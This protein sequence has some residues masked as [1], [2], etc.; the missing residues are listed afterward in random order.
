[1]W[2]RILAI[3]CIPVVLLLFMSIPYSFRTTLA[4]LG[5]HESQ[6]FRGGY[7]FGMV[8]GFTITALAIFFLGR[9]ILRTLRPPKKGTC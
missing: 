2:K 8:I 1:M 3:L 6:A 5:S 7:Y 4:Q 9:W